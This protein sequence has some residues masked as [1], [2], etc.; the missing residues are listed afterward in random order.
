[1]LL[2]PF[3]PFFAAFSLACLSSIATAG[4]GG[5]KNFE[6][7]V[8]PAQDDRSIYDKIWSLA[9]LYHNDGAIVQDVSFT[10]RAQLDYNHLESNVG[11]NDAWEVRRL[12]AGLKVK[13][14]DKWL[15]HGEVDFA[16]QD[17]EDTSYRRMTDIYLSYTA[18][19]AFVFTLGKHSVKFTLDGGTSSKELTAIDRSN[20]A[21]NLWF[22]EE[23]APGVSVA[24]KVRRWQ[25][26][27]GWFS[28]DGNPEFGNF[29]AG[30]FLLTSVGYDFAEQLR[31][32]KAVLRL[33]YVHQTPDEGNEATRPFENIGS[34]NFNLEKGRFGLGADFSAGQGYGKQGDVRGFTVMPSWH[35]SKNVQLVLRYTQLHGDD[36]AIRF[37]RYESH[38]TSGR[39]DRYREVYA[40][41]N[42]YLYGHKLKLQTGIQYATMDDSRHDG[43][44]Y[45]GW[46]LVSGLRV[47]W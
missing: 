8:T 22:S 6:T 2:R 19:D 28:S 11:D 23:Y 43:G 12:R 32:D 41:A 38:V 27:L 9:K 21:N 26:F 30:T 31:A 15:L 42:W 7:A 5:A 39:G 46:S 16:N 47:S 36:N 37:A 13:F 10:G 45:D 18:S 24:G 44:D 3:R 1:M 29:D 34:L 4:A 40:G 33:D 17:F 14:L 20:L 25:Y 35:A